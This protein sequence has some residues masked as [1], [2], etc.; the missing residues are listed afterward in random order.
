VR[1]GPNTVLVL[2]GSR[3]GGDPLAH[4]AG[5]SHKCLIPVGGV[6]MLE[7][8]LG[9]LGRLAAAPRIVIAID[10]PEILDGL[11]Q[12]Q[13][14]LA[15]G[16]LRVIG[17]A[18]SPSRTVLSALQSSSIALPFL[19]TTADHPLLT[20]EMILAFWRRVPEEADLAAA[21][22]S[23]KIIRRA[24]PETRR[25]YLPFADD[26]YSGCNLFAINTVRA[27][28]VLE[29]WQQVEARRKR[30]LAMIR[31]LGPLATLRFL[32]K[33]MTLA[34]AVEH[35][36]AL[37]DTRLAAIPLPFADAAIDVDKPDDLV[38]ARRILA[39]R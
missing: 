30:P 37:T 33:R 4:E 24:W 23:A 13:A 3:G 2:A 10:R 32:L 1:T 21:V 22:A 29:F 25:T 16:R 36:G 19:V 39:R 18:T 38:L 5:V 28:R 11:P 7:R 14:A 35:L 6:T 34:A 15:S 26:R 17:T 9:V 31:L 12:T 20:E 8:I 27:Q